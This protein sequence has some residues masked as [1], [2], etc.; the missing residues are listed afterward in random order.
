[1]RTVA[2]GYVEIG[3]GDA[4]RDDVGVVAVLPAL[5]AQFGA[6]GPFK[7]PSGVNWF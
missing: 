3:D 2:R 5:H 1:M 7:V 6:S 4:R